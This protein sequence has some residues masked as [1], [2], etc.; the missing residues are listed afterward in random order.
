M[1]QAQKR[2]ASRLG[3]LMEKATGEVST[4]RAID[5][6][7]ALGQKGQQIDRCWIDSEHRV[8]A[9]KF[10]PLPASQIKPVWKWIGASI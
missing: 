10:R 2:Q 7:N 9:I 5:Y 1:S 4:Q 6:V 8:I 3:W